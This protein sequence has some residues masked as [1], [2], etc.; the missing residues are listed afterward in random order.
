MTKST[1]RD[2][3]QAGQSQGHAGSRPQT[4]L[5]AKLKGALRVLVVPFAPDAYRPERHYMRG[6]GPKAQA[7][8]PPRDDADK[9]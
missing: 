8:T 9:G 3:T 6:P 4:G 2:E 1:R 7:K 5:A